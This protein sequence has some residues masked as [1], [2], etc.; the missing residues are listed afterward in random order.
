MG[1]V[2]TVEFLYSKSVNDFVYNKLNIRNENNPSKLAQDGRPLYGGT[3]SKNNN[4]TDVMYLKNTDQG[5][6][7][8]LAFQVQR[9]VVR[10]LSVNAGYTYGR[11]EDLNSVNSSQ[12]NSQMRYNPI[13]GNPNDPV[14]A[15]S[16]YEIRGRVFLSL[17]YVEEFFKNAPTTISLFYNGESG[18]PFS[19]IYG[20][21]VN[22]DGFDQN[23]LFYIPKDDNDI[24]LGSIS[25]G[26]FVR[27]DAMYAAF[28]SFV[29]NNEYLASHRGQIAER[30]ADVNPWVDYLDLHISQDIPIFMDHVLTVNYDILNVLNLLSSD[31]GWNSSVFSTYRVANKVGTLATG[32]EAG[33]NVYSFAAPSN[34]TPFTPSNLASRWQMQLGIRYTF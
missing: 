33:Q 29:D 11:A 21:D 7:Y 6:S 20:S 22:L 34:N 13:A 9:S 12:A 16:Q 28:N 27:N 5:Y 31:W 19:Y 3:D 10:G 26:A 25:G 14:L 23:D 17:S 8:N 4:F 15:T 32:P 30:N 2:G 18:A 24:L 1:F